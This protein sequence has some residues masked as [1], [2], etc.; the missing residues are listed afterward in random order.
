MNS[1]ISKPISMEEIKN[2][3]AGRPNLDG[4]TEAA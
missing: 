4:Q 3:L 2:S 1:F